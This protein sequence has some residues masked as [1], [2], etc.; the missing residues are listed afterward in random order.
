MP[1]K[2]V[3]FFSRCKPRGVSAVDVAVQFK[4]VF[5]GYTILKSG[6]AFDR[7]ALTECL[8]DVSCDDEAWQAHRAEPRE[9]RA[10]HAKNRNFVRAVTPGSIAMVPSLQEGV[11]HC[12]RVG[13]FRLRHDEAAYAAFAPRF[14]SEFPDQAAQDSVRLAGEI[15]QGW[16]VEGDFVAVPVP[17]IPASIRRSLFGR[18]TYG[19]IKPDEDRPAPYA[20][21]AAIMASS[22]FTPREWSRDPVEVGR[23]LSD[24]VTPAM[25]EGLV[26]SLLQLEQPELVWLPV[27]GSGDGGV[28]GIAARPDGSVA[29]LLQCK[30]RYGGEPVFNGP[31]LATLAAYGSQRPKTYLATL[32][33]SSPS[34]GVADEVL[35]KRWMTQ[36]II[37][38]CDRL[39]LAITLRVGGPMN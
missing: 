29:A 23:R 25:F 18:S 7:N 21:M 17:R 6:Q 30:W 19:I 39:P 35:D 20:T 12:G 16:D 32:S 28:D 34:L 37:E 13:P 5:F 26:A 10:Q 22:T 15:G 27:G 11:I 8:L 38:H 36:K 3:L 1:D 24:V 4:R 2:P 9:D 31:A 14:Q 33:G